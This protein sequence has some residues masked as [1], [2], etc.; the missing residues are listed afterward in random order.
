MIS[1]LAALLL[2][3]SAIVLV[4]LR[5]HRHTPTGLPALT[6][7]RAFAAGMVFVL[8]F[9]HD[10][11]AELPGLLP[12]VVGSGYEYVSVFFVLSGF[13]LTLSIRRELRAKQFSLRQY[14]IRRAARILPLYYA[15]LAIT[16]VLTP[17]AV[18][19]QNVLL[20]QSFFNSTLFTGIVAAWT[21]PIEES[22]YLVLPIVIWLCVKFGKSNGLVICCLVLMFAGFCMVALH[23]PNFIINLNF[24]WSRT[25]FGRFPLFAMGV[26]CA[27][28]YE[29]RKQWPL[30]LLILS[31]GWL[32]AATML[33]VLETPGLDFRLADMFVGL[34]AGGVVL[35]LASDNRVTRFLGNRYFVYL[36][37]ISYALYLVH[38]TPL[39]AWL[40]PL[41]SSPLDLAA[42]YAIAT[43]LSV[44]LY[45]LLEQ[46]A[47]RA[48]LNRFALMAS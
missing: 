35:G 2:I 28:M 16:F 47:R 11:G 37:V 46:P 29:R 10:F 22:F 1:P 38:L 39:M 17:D 34:A 44:A 36:G 26:A 48:I 33:A 18:H 12:Y 19:W 3:I 27:F 4:A 13:L 45:E 21:L 8:H 5:A 24:M 7:L 31:G 15:L 14:F 6:S 25:I 41:V 20:A 43:L 40:I 42:A 30:A 9:V 32:I 23:I